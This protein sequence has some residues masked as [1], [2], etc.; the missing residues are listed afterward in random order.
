MTVCPLPRL[1]A[2]LEHRGTGIDFGTV[3]DNVVT[4]ELRF[5]SP[6]H[7]RHLS[8]AFHIDDP[9]VLRVSSSR[10]PVSYAHIDVA[11]SVIEHVVYTVRGVWI[12]DRAEHLF[13]T[14]FILASDDEA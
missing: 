7:V 12:T 10:N 11:S 13:C 3:V 5:P 14:L 4:V 9:P 6:H 2:R 8:C 1:E